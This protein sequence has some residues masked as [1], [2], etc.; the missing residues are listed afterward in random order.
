MLSYGYSL[1]FGSLLVFV[2][3]NQPNPHR[4]SGDTVNVL[5]YGA[6]GD[7]VTDDTA[8]F[9]RAHDALPPSG[10]TLDIPP[11]R[12][13]YVVDQVRITKPN[14]RVTGSGH[15]RKKSGSTARG[16]F[17]LENLRPA[18]FI[19]EGITADLGFVGSTAIGSGVIFARRTTGIRVSN[20]RV[21]D[22]AEN[23]FTFFNCGDVRLD[24]IYVD[25]CRNN[26][27][28]FNNHVDGSDESGA[29][30]QTFANYEV[31]NSYFGHV[32]DGKSGRGDGVSVV[33]VANNG[34]SRNVRISG[35]TIENGLFGVHFE[36]SGVG[37]YIEDFEISDNTVRDLIADAVTVVSAKN[38][39][40]VGNRIFNV[41][42]ASYIA[43]GD[44][45]GITVT[46][47]GVTN[48]ERIR[49]ADNMIKESRASQ[50]NYMEIGVLVSSCRSCS[51]VKNTIH[52]GTQ[53]AIV[54]ADVT[55]DT[56]VSGNTLVGAATP[57]SASGIEFTYPGRVGVTL[58]ENNI[59]GFATNYIGLKNV[60]QR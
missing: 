3:V 22:S 51:V 46:T 34:V 45:T 17:F 6:K 59:S 44:A 23:A 13:D 60:T 21:M 52:G 41:G 9:Q 12:G 8:A 38:G 10:G 58:A 39:T 47:N 24:H 1:L 18:N 11:R 54:L 14:V 40:I 56:L 36:H 27:V 19:L 37:N 15:V 26:G 16:I 30:R 20:V 43:I 31:T 5:E 55:G 4:S 42:K 53:A 48:S 35:N 25:H 29:L 32:D 49:I 2:L 50:T 28:E 7:G 57:R 33:F